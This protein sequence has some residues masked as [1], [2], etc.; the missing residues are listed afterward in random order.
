MGTAPTRAWQSGIPQH[1]SPHV[2][3]PFQTWPRGHVPPLPAGTGSAW[4]SHTTHC[5]VPYDSTPRPTPRGVPK[6]LSP[7]CALPQPQPFIL[8]AIRCCV[9]ALQPSTAMPWDPS[10]LHELCS[11]SASRCSISPLAPPQSLMVVSTAAA[12]APAAPHARGLW[13]A[14]GEARRKAWGK[15]TT[16]CIDVRASRPE[17]GLLL[18]LLCLHLCSLQGQPRPTSSVCVLVHH[19]C[20]GFNLI[21]A[22][23]NAARGDTGPPV[24]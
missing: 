5:L 17:P 20:S 14:Q 6:V 13:E 1:C 3:L 23:Q 12:A 19:L 22:T 18:A 24:L 7:C 15:S 9:Q 8:A 21:L 16:R 2:G 4:G 10:R 11:T